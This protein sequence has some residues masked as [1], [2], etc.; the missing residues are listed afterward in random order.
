M[1]L[2]PLDYRDDRNRRSDACKK[3]RHNDGTVKSWDC[4]GMC[5]LRDDYN[6]KVKAGNMKLELLNFFRECATIPLTTACHISPGRL[7]IL[8]PSL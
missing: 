6:V 3:I 4:K 5:D 7:S 1:R 8:A 2:V